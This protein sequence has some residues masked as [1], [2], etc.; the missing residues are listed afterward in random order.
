MAEPNRPYEG[1]AR[2][3]ADIDSGRTGDKVAHPD[4]AMSP[5][6]TDDEAAGNPPSRVEV[7]TARAHETWNPARQAARDGSHAHSTARHG[8]GS[9]AFILLIAAVAVVIVV[10]VWALR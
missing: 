3:R 8:W 4:P 1:A 10:G 2:L 9:P 6:G 5:L 7:M